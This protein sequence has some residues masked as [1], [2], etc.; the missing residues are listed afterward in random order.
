MNGP[1]SIKQMNQS[2]MDPTKFKNI[3]LFVS[4]V[5]KQNSNGNQIAN[6]KNFENFR[7]KWNSR[8]QDLLPQQTA[9]GLLK[10]ELGKTVKQNEQP[11]RTVLKK[12]T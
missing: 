11:S 4:I 1:N 12:H 10:F 6:C 9:L 2:K 7:V 5:I 3:K 8:I